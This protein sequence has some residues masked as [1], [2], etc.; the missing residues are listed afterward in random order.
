LQTGGASEEPEQEEQIQ[1]PDP[2]AEQVQQLTEMGFSE[3]LGRKAL[4]LCRGNVELALEWVLG[5]MDDADAEEP[6]TQEQ[7][8][9]VC[10]VL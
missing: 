7:L 1:V 5:H 3:A 6:P 2:P 4:I 8:R 10:A 9:Q